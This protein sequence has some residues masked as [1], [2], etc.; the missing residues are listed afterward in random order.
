MSRTL[1]KWS[2]NPEL[3]ASLKDIVLKLFGSLKMFVSGRNFMLEIIFELIDVSISDITYS[4]SELFL[5]LESSFSNEKA[6]ILDF[7]KLSDIWLIG[8]LLTI[9]PSTI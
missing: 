7:S 4:L 6:T 9:P 1:S 8:R 2:S 5:P 3:N